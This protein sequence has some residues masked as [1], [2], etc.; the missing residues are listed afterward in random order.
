[1]N[2][3]QLPYLF[4]VI[5]Q[6]EGSLKEDQLKEIC[7]VLSVISSQINDIKDIALVVICLDL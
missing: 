3:S 4:S 1:M 6:I 7:L 5:A 2:Y